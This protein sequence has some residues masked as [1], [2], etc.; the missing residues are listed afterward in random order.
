MIPQLWLWMM[1]DI[2][3]SALPSNIGCWNPESFWNDEAPGIPLNLSGDD[4]ITHL[5]AELNRENL[6]AHESTVYN[7][8]QLTAL[9]LSETINFLNPPR[10]A[11]LQEPILFTFQSYVAKLYDNVQTYVK[12]YQID[13]IE[14]KL[15]KDFLN[16]I[17]DV[18]D[19]LNMIKS[20]IDQQDKVWRKFYKDFEEVIKRW[21]TNLIRIVTRPNEQTPEFKSRIEKIEKDAQRVQDV[22]QAQLSLKSNHVGLKESHNSTILSTAVLALRSSPSSSN[23]CPS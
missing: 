19:E 3:I 6:Q 8:L 5:R 20:I 18:F 1:D 23:H 21:D 4:P 9:I 17:N 12:K 15:Q 13:S 22:M 10:C 16:E 7:G 11:E 14:V 2:V